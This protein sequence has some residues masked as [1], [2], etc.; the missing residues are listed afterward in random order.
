MNL[1]TI[2]VLACLV[3]L[4]GCGSGTPA[5]PDIYTGTNGLVVEFLPESPPKVAYEEDNF[6]IAMRIK[7]DGPTDIA[8]GVLAVAIEE[9]FF[10]V[11][12]WD[13]ESF[14]MD[15]EMIDQYKRSFA[16][17]GKRL[18][19]PIAEEGIVIARM[20]AHEL[21]D[22]VEVHTSL[23]TATICYPYQTILNQEV[24]IE[25]DVFDTTKSVKVCEAE[26]ISLSSQG[27][28]V[29]I[30][31]IEPTMRP[32]EDGTRISPHFRF[33]IQNAGE[34]TVISSDALTACS[35]SA[36]RKDEVNEITMDAWLFNRKLSCNPDT[37]RLDENKQAEVTCEL[38][39]GVEMEQDSYKSM[40]V[41]ELDYGYTRTIAS[42]V[43]IKK[44]Q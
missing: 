2:I 40:L 1:K 17:D 9:N 29:A 19:S 14:S 25:G 38:T 41:V 31:R 23:V 26:T 7:N 43:E 12:G 42:N 13:Q 22:Q 35:S 36:I 30:T 18:D 3:L 32:S 24:C 44:R 27:G 37:F 16:I 39:S 10:E 8:G 11:M 15:L 6:L 5:L 4:T 34:G 20:K 33:T 28:P 21:P